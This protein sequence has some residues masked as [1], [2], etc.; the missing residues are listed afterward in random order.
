VRVC[1]RVYKRAII[2]DSIVDTRTVDEMTGLEI[3]L[4]DFTLCLAKARNMTYDRVQA[5][6]MLH[7]I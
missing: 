5:T 3:Y 2:V 6:I 1:E 4:V 7:P